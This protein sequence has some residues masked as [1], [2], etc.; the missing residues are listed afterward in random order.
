MNGITLNLSSRPF[1][2][3][4]LVASVLASAVLALIAATLYNGYVF[5]NYGGRYHDLQQEEQVHRDRLAGLESDERSLSRE[6]QARDF[7]RLMG[8]G[9][10]VADLIL[11]RSFSWTL[12]FNKLED[13]VPP[14]VMMTAIRPHI[15]GEKTV[16]RVDGVAKNHGGLIAFED[17]LQKN[18]VFARV[19][20]VYERRVNPSR[21]EISFA[22]DFDYIPAK[23]PPGPDAI[24]S[25][26]APG[27]GEAPPQT[28]APAPTTF[29]PA[30]TATPAPSSGAVSASGP[31]AEKG[32]APSAAAASDTRA[33]IGT[34]GR[35]GRPRTPEVLARVLAAPGGVYPQAPPL[36]PP[37]PAGASGKKSRGRPRDGKAPNSTAPAESA[38]PATVPEVSPA[39]R[40]DVAPATQVRS[41]RKADA[42]AHRTL[43]PARLLGKK[44]KPGPP[45]APGPVPATRLDVPLKFS[46]RPVGDVYGA[47]SQAHGVRFEFDPTVDQR[48]KVSTDL[49]GKNLKDAIAVVSKLAGHKVLRVEDGRYRVIPLAG[50]EPLS[51]RPIQE[52]PLG[53]TEVNP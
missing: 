16:I 42:P 9:Q 24:A 35:D 50:G 51:D 2:N 47:L 14:E 41:Q 5:M 36:A 34:V 26:A 20:P 52:E 7:R 6:I 27:Q 39:T 30:A 37:E 21:P 44:P 40:K 38:P 48:A 19:Y 15:T 1:R 33:V 13:V 17:S 43:S 32:G 29:A 4:T 3:N 53:G 45:G 46:A 25:G 22:L 8:R 12:L 11:R 28:M 23:E 31:G 49:A 18:P 10:F